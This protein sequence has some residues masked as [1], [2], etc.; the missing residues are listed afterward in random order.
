MDAAD[1]NDDGSININDIIYLIS[2]L[3]FEPPG[4]PPPPPFPDPGFDPT[5]DGLG[6]ANACVAPV[7]SAVDFLEVSSASGSA[8]EVTAVPII[9]TNSQALLA[10]QIHLEFDPNIL[11]VTD[12]DTSGTATGAAHPWR[13][14]F[15][16]PTL[17]GTVEI[18]CYIDSLRLRSI[19]VGRDTLVKIMFQV[20]QSASCATTLL[21]LKTV[22]GPPFWGN[23]LDYAGGNVYPTLVDG[24]FTVRFKCGDANA[25]GVVD[26]TDVLYLIN[27]LFLV[28][29]G[30]A[31]KPLAAGDVN[32]DG[33]INVSD[34][35]YL[36]N[37]LFLIPPGPPPCG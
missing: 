29:P 26:V 27:Y 24:N 28:P 31:P 32:C 1:V 21:D 34:V 10:Y 36:I 33:V 9:V 30:P 11:Q 18:W 35:L 4:D 19:P 8:C 37:F 22:T 25:N 2:Y 12:V 20:N 7:N 3:L 6:C 15:G 13:F 16:T 17:G 23:L 14:G 5:P